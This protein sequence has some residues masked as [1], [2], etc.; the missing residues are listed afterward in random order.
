MTSTDTWSIR[1]EAPGLEDVVTGP[2]TRT[3][4]DVLV[5][6]Y[7]DRDRE[8]AAE[9][10]GPTRRRIT[11]EEYNHSDPNLS[12][13]IPE[14]EER[15]SWLG[16]VFFAAAGVVSLFFAFHTYHLQIVTPRPH[17]APLAAWLAYCGTFALLSFAGAV[18]GAALTWLMRRRTRSSRRRPVEVTS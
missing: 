5:G 10:D 16:T 13:V 7:L 9:D 14:G 3:Q 15:T 18:V 8:E 4:A 12:P 11:V 2:L 1:I 6:I 17:D